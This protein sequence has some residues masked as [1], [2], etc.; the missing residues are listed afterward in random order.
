MKTIFLK[1]LI[2]IVL[3]ISNI[4][5]KAQQLPLNTLMKD[6]PANAYVK[7]LDNELTP[8]IGKYKTNYQGNE[9]TLF[10]TKEENRP[11]KRMNKNF[12]RDALSIRY[13]VKN[14]S[15]IVLQNTQNMNIGNQTYFNIV[16]IGTIPALGNVTLGYDGTNCGIGWGEIILKKLNP[17]QISWEYRPNSLV[18]DSATCPP[19]TDKT[20]YLPVT[21]DLIFTKQ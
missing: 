16:S 8:Y 21:K 10:I 5:C 7:D 13:I 18:I 11:T 15:G 6:I 14:S 12:Y 19:S 17:T 9:I 4:S 1:T 3:L 20:V 2:V